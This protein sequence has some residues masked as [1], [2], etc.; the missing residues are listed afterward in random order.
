MKVRQFDVVVLHLTV[1]HVVAS[2]DDHQG[3]LIV[4]VDWHG[5]VVVD[6]KECEVLLQ[7]EGLLCCV[8]QCVELQSRRG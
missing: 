3:A 5:H 6:A 1:V 7:V 8:G 2:T 4:V